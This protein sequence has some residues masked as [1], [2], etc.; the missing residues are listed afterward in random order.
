M[1][2]AATADHFSGQDLA[3]K[4]AGVGSI[5][6]RFTAAVAFADRTQFRTLMPDQTKLSFS[7]SG[8]S[9]AVCLAAFSRNMHGLHTCSHNPG[10]WGEEVAGDRE[11]LS[12]DACPHC[13]VNLQA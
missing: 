4:S 5:W 11:L 2:A 9:G 13:C 12:L 6:G 8:A 7:H 3:G 1:M 10:V